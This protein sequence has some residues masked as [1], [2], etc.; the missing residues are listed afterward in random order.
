VEALDRRREALVEI[1]TM[2]TGSPIALSRAQQADVMIEHLAWFADAAVRG[3][4]GGF[5]N[6]LPDRGTGPGGGGSVLVHEPIGVVAALTPY[7][8]PFVTAVWKIGGALASGS[9]AVLQPSPRSALS[10]LAWVRLLSE[11]DLPPGTVSFLCGGPQVGRQ[12]TESGSVDMVTFTGS[13]GVG[14][15]VM[16]QASA[17]LKRLVLE[18][19]GKSPNVILPGTDIEAVVGPSTLR[20]SRNAGQAC[21]ATTRTFVP[22]RHYDDFVAA[23]GAFLETVKVGS[24]WSEDTVVGPLIS[25][26]HRQRVDGY[27]ERALSE[28]GVIEAGGGRPAAGH[29]YFLNPALVGR[30]DNRSE[31]AREE[32]FGPVSVVIPYDDVASAIAMANDSDYGLNANVWGP[33]PEALDVARRIRSG[34]VTVNGGG[35]GLRPDAPFGGYRHS[36]IGREAGEAGFLEFFEVKQLQWPIG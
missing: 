25:A 11:A 17:N 4:R 1:V 2:E 12:L 7:N 28:G 26:E 10:S 35:G 19:G 9:T 29:G 6:R 32:L 15:S 30:V 5:E 22:R 34:T 27:L 14:R 20:F 16:R 21:G 23:T 31:I 24:P 33:E 3:P 36:G 13:T 18:L 8:A